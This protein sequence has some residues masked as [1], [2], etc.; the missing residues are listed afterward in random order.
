MS[1]STDANFRLNAF[2]TLF[3]FILLLGCLWHTALKWAWFFLLAQIALWR[4][5]R[6]RKI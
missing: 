2:E 1:N 4:V 3:Y 6:V 5:Q